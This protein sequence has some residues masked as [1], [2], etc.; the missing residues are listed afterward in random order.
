MYVQVLY[1]SYK[2]VEPLVFSYLPFAYI[3][4]TYTTRRVE[5]VY[6]FQAQTGVYSYIIVLKHL[7]VGICPTQLKFHQAF[8]SRFLALFA[9]SRF[10]VVLP[11]CAISTTSRQTPKLTEFTNKFVSARSK[12]VAIKSIHRESS[13][14]RIWHAFFW[15]ERRKLVAYRQKRP[16]L[17]VSAIR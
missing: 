8:P 14:V 2:A 10:V 5:A 17:Y 1:L 16:V 4:H 15:R 9:R 13:F 3:Y 6:F 7:R 12:W 11:L